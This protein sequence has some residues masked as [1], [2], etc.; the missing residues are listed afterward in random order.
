MATIL[1]FSFTIKRDWSNIE[2]AEFARAAALLRRSG[3]QIACE[4]GLSDEGDPWT[5]FLRQDTGDVI[6]HIA[7][8]DGRILAASTASGDV[9]AGPNLRSVM[10]KIVRSQPLVMLPPDQSGQ[11]HLHPATVLLAFIA[12][13]F[14]W[15][16]KNDDSQ[17]H[18]WC[19]GP[20]GAVEAELRGHAAPAPGS[21]L[22]RDAVLSKSELSR[23]GFEVRFALSDSMVLA[24]ATA[25]LAL[26]AT[27]TFHLDVGTL[28][29]GLKE[30]GQAPEVWATPAQHDG[31]V[32][33]L[34]DRAPVFFTADTALR[35]ENGAPHLRTIPESTHVSA[36]ISPALSDSNDSHIQVD[37]APG[38][39][40][41]PMPIEPENFLP[42]IFGIDANTSKNAAPTAS[43]ADG[44]S[45]PTHDDLPTHG[46]SFVVAPAAAGQLLALVFGVR[47]ASD[48]PASV[49]ATAVEHEFNGP[50]TDGAALGG[51]S[52]TPPVGAAESAANG[53]Q[54][55]AEIASF[56]FNPA[57]ELSP[58]PAE[59]QVF[60]Q[61]LAAQP[62]LPTTNKIL[63]IDTPD[64]QA[65]L[66]KFS[67]SLAMMSQHT[68]EKL[69][70]GVPMTAQTEL[71]L[72][73]GTVLKLIGVIDLHPDPH[74]S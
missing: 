19:V 44:A 22:L 4:W 18:E 7:K 49:T 33:Q 32:P 53:Y 6:A 30:F 37:H 1:R 55:L 67:G 51:L 42:V 10:D 11:I 5:V 16:Q 38:S 61:T 40:H 47:D 8:I 23:L 31:D 65:D 24:A 9:V 29:G 60:Q 52:P 72:S 26:A 43:G 20:N 39:D 21:N 57:H 2:Q 56:A 69:L 64:L 14:V 27:D 66:F 50:P 28:L 25:A 58:P 12:T 3:L 54:L 15:S 70:P 45:A 35:D 63:I 62:F 34:G 71:P 68:V 13:A 73:D 36:T 46:M 17:R 48:L 59:L 41:T 74:L